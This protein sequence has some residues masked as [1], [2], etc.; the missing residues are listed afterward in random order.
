MRTLMRTR[1]SCKVE[2][3]PTSNHR[4]QS[5][6]SEFLADDAIRSRRDANWGSHRQWGPGIR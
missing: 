3:L 2:Y 1:P 6:A 4:D 5:V